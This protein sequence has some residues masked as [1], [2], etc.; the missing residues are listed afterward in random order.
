[1]P[2][3]ER[4]SILLLVTDIP[5]R[6]VEYIR[7]LGWQK[8]FENSEWDCVKKVSV[9]FFRSCAFCFSAW[10]CFWS[11]L[12][13]HCCIHSTPLHLLIYLLELMI[14][15]FTI[16]NIDQYDPRAD[17]TGSCSLDYCN[18]LMTVYLTSSFKDYKFN[19]KYCC[20][21]RVVITKMWTYIWHPYMLGFLYIYADPPY[22][23]QI[24]WWSR[25]SLYY[26]DLLREYQPAR[27]S[28]YLKIILL[29][30]KIVI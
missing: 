20:Q 19:T 21:P 4:S 17:H 18:S 5:L 30:F 26:K 14:W 29:P 6:R 3:S 9:V 23:L 13:D 22:H 8:V 11:S 10:L 24:P 28:Y 27:N 7:L 1:M 25:F 2:V 12:L 16:W 15:I